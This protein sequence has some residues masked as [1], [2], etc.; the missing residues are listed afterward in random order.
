MP[1]SPPVLLEDIRH[2]AQRIQTIQQHLPVLKKQAE[3]PLAGF[4]PP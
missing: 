3:D 4:A 2:A 1:H